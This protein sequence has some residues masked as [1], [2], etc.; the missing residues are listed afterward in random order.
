MEVVGDLLHH[1][2]LG[3]PRRGVSGQGNVLLVFMVPPVQ[4]DV[5]AVAVEL[6]PSLG[7]VAAPVVDQRDKG[8]KQRIV[9]QA[10][11]ALATGQGSQQVFAL[12]LSLNLGLGAGLLLGFAVGANSPGGCLTQHGAVPAA[13]KAS[14]GVLVE[15]PHPDHGK[16]AAE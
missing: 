14:H 9:G 6:G 10:A 5:Q 8:E 3:L 4:K 1:S 7:Q 2:P 16:V 12:F 13:H 11:Q 15:I